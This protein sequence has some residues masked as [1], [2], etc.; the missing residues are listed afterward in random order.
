V[1]GRESRTDRR[2]LNDIV[3]R[4]LF[5]AG[6]DL[7]VALGLIGEHRAAGTVQR[8]VSELDLAIRDIRNVVFGSRRPGRPAAGRAG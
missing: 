3:V 7:E 1:P 5:S 8:A 6:L 4:R 2:G